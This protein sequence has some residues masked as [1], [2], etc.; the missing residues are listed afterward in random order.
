MMIMVSFLD[1][2]FL[3]R[4]TYR[5]DPSRVLDGLHGPFPF[6]FT[7]FAL[8]EKGDW[9]CSTLKSRISSVQTALILSVSASS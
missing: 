6:L 4:N 7:L 3:K 1:S 8:K 2:P 9:V 5:L